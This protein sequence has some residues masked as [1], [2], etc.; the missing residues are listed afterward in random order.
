MDD[1]LP[2]TDETPSD[3][4]RGEVV[5]WVVVVGLLV[6][7]VGLLLASAQKVYRP[8]PYEAGIWIC[9]DWAYGWPFPFL[10]REDR[11]PFVTPAPPEVWGT[12]DFSL[13]F[14]AL[15]LLAGLVLVVAGGGLVWW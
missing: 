6:I 9:E 7:L 15:D 11:T 13:G 10:W 4:P 2:R 12:R 8:D 1:S 14:L 5:G 3:P